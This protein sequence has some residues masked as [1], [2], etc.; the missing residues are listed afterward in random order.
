MVRVAEYWIKTPVTKKIAKMSDGRT[1]D[2]DE[3][4]AALDELASQGVTGLKA[5]LS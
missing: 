1:I 4:G 3:D 2:L 5:A